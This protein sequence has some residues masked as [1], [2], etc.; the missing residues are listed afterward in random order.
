[1][2]RPTSVRV[3]LHWVLPD[4]L[5]FTMALGNV[6]ITLLQIQRVSEARFQQTA[7]LEAAMGNRHG[8]LGGNRV[9]IHTFA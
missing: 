3:K 2:R 4:E 8:A 5:T 7:G 1:M 6:R 9:T